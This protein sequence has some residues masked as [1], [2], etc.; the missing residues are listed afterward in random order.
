[1]F[2]VHAVSLCMNAHKGVGT[3]GGQRVSGPLELELQVAVSYLTSCWSSGRV[4]TLNPR[5]SLQPRQLGLIR[6][7]R[8]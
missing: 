3:H 5:V 8:V 1:M 2:Y 6:E 4:M 7:R